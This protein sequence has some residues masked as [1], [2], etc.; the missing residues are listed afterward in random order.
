MNFIA[1]AK[2][3][4]KQDFTIAPPKFDV[5]ILQLH[6]AGETKDL[7]LNLSE[8]IRISFDL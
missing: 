4:H 5:V 7:E 6:K 2:S 1:V 3:S 8:D